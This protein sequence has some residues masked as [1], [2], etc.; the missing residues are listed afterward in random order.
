MEVILYVNIISF[1]L[2]DLTLWNTADASKNQTAVVYISI[3]ITLSLTV[4][5]I[6][7]HT[8][9]YTRLLFIIKSIALKFKSTMH[10]VERQV[11]IPN[12]V[13]YRQPLITYSVVELPRNVVDPANEEQNIPSTSP[14]DV[15]TASMVAEL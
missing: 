6:F 2:A 15:I 9:Y 1:K 3:T 8:F 14:D 13:E 10:Q 11:D 5:V 4:T 12:D 7:F